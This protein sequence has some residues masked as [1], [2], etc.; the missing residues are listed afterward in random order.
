MGEAIDSIGAKLIEGDEAAE[1]LA[2]FIKDDRFIKYLAQAIQKNE[3][4]MRHLAKFKDDRALNAIVSRIGDENQEVRR[5]VSVTLALSVHPKAF[6]YLLKMRNDNFY[7][8]RLDVT[9]FLGKTKTAEST[10]LLK[11]MMSDENEQN[12]NEAKR[13]LLERGEKL[14]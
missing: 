1:K 8:I 14:K 6:V 2:P 13:Y 12:R 9:H 3:W 7:A 10:K 5:N 4:L 11:E